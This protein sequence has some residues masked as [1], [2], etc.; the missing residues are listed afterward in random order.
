MLNL[1]EKADIVNGYLFS[2][3]TPAGTYKKVDESLDLS[4]NLTKNGQKLI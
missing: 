1:V 4:A 3:Q 2:I